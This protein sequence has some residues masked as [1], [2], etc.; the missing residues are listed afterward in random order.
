[1]AKA[2]K[3]ANVEHKRV[4]A[5]WIKLLNVTTPLILSLGSVSLMFEFAE[6][7]MPSSSAYQDRYRALRHNTVGLTAEHEL[8][9]SPMAMRRHHNQ[10]ATPRF[11]GM[12]NG[13]GRE[14]IFDMNRLADNPIKRSSISDVFKI[15]PAFAVAAFSYSS[16]GNCAATSSGAETIQGSVTLTIVALALSTFAR[17]NP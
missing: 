4:T 15:L 11:G 7:S 13:L 5:F 9:Q 10:V 6:R 14:L 16:T 1:M 17:P 8:H 2:L 12:D 3:S